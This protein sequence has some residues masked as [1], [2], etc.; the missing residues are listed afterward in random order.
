VQRVTRLETGIELEVAGASHHFDEVILACHSDQALA[1]LSNPTKDETSILGDLAYQANDVILHMDASIMPKKSLSWAS[2][3]FL[4]GQS[5][6]NQAPIV[7]YCMNILQGIHST[8]P[9]LVTLNARHKID[10]EKILQEFIYDHPV[11][12][13]ESVAAQNRRKE[14][15]GTDRIHYCGA[16]WYSGFHEDGV[17]SALDVCERFGEAL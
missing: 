2:W 13:T 5:E 14:I 15:C 4:A 10:P 9:F 3:N 7:T 6:L 1:M 17:H 8:R 11:Y 16:Y 12:S